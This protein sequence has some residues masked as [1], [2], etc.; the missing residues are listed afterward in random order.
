MLRYI[1]ADELNDYPKLRDT[2]FHDR[3][4]QFKDR[5][6]WD[7]IVDAQGFERDEYDTLDTL[8]VIWIMPNGS[9]GGSMRVLPTMGRVMVN[10]HFGDV[11][12]HEIHSEHIWET[13]RFCLSPGL[14]EQ[15]VQVSA[16]LMLAG[17]QIG[18]SK[19]LESMIAIFDPRMIRVYRRLGW[20]PKI[21]GSVGEG[22]NKIFAGA[23]TFDH[24]ILAR[25][26]QQAGIPEVLSRMWYMRS[27]GALNSIA[28]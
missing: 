17:C 18:I 4:T 7:V 24:E 14:N 20:P 3:A 8:Y 27:M 25:M 12:G 28:A 10:E 1:Y 23:W 13:T 21:L 11:I 16:A 9:H 22:H 5:L 2:M 6:K 15:G 19:G 26:A